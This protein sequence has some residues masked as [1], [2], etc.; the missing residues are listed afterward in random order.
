MKKLRIAINGYGRIG[1]NFLLTICADERAKSQIEVVAI[2]GG[3]SATD[4]IAYL[5]K[6]DTFL[7]IYP[8][9]ISAENDHI[10]ID[11]HRI[12]VLAER[13]PEKLP[14]KEL[15]ID[16]VVD[17][18]GAFTKAAQAQRHI[19]AGAQKV[20]ISA[21][22]TGEDITIIPGINMQA[23]NAAEHAIV[24]LGSCTTNAIVP[25]LA[26][27]D[28]AFG[29]DTAL[30]TTVHAYTNSQA[31]LDVERRDFRDSRAAALNTVPSTTGAN[32]TVVKVLP[33]LAGKCHGMSL[34]VPTGK[35]SIMDLVCTLHKSPNA[36]M[37]HEAFV[38]AAQSDLKG[39]L[40]VTNDPLVSSDI[41]KNS[42]SVI[43]DTHLTITHGRVCKT[44]GWYDNE[45]GYSCR[46]RDFLMHTIKG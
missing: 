22:A 46:M 3:G 32:K 38:Q 42:H 11:G 39:I 29:I 25:M 19:K 45:W 44:F 12:R 2:N 41:N 10:V 9:T 16:W 34:R 27:L 6:F 20:L 37:V 33:Q 36:D 24:S 7:G 1:K 5:T 40:Q 18:T 21:P 4:M 28:K 26:V 23:Y 35:G 17:C 13:E 8:G 14:W 30:F 15:A 31:L 43:I